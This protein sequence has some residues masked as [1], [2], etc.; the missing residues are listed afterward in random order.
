MPLR[1]PNFL[2]FFSDQHRGDWMPYS[3]QIKQRL[4]VKQLE[5]H[6][7]N[8]QR[9]MENGLTFTC[10]VSPA[11]VCAPARACLASGQR[12]RNCRVYQNNVNYDPTLP[13]F[14]GILKE[15]GYFVTGAGKFDLNKANLTWGN[16]YHDTLRHGEMMGDHGLYGK[17]RPEQGSIHIPLVIDASHFGGI[18]NK[19]LRTP[20][21]LQD[22]A[23]TF[24]DYAGASVPNN[25]ES[26][27]LRPLTEGTAQQVRETAL[28][29]LITRGKGT[30]KS[31]GCVTDGTWKLIMRPNQPDRLYHIE[32]DPFECKDIITEH[33][34]EAERLR[35]AFDERGASKHPAL[36]KYTQS[37][38]VGI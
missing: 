26:M 15:N 27:S 9:I 38:H 23:A 1:K 33:P 4:G 24:L 10:A 30:L 19:Y 5:L 35:Q 13:S 21:E 20:V 2:F 18:K 6:M 22:L 29:E 11:P 14:Y 37:F 16:G 8:I 17:S 25:W 3:Q 34:Q 31:F 32:N 7:P 36:Q 12:Y 28:S